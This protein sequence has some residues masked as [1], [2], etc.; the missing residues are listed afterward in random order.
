[1]GQYNKLLFWVL[2]ENREVLYIPLLRVMIETP[3]MWTCLTQ[4]LAESRQ[5]A[6]GG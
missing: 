5:N 6:K 1:M 3:Q 2:F 4:D